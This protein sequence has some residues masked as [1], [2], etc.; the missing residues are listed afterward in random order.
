MRFVEDGQV[1]N[2]KIPGSWVESFKRS[3]ISIGRY[4]SFVYTQSVEFLSGAGLVFGS[5]AQHSDFMEWEFL[6][7]WS[8]TTMTVVPLG[9]TSYYLASHRSWFIDLK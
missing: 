8:I 2:N 7:I 6:A 1:G 5:S 4:Q 9:S 3:N